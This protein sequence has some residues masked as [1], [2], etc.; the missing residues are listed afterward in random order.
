[1]DYV[2]LGQNIKRFRKIAGLT[3]AKLAE[4]AG[5]CVSFIGQLE[6]ADTKPSL[7]TLVNIAQA[8]SVTVDQLLIAETN[9]PERIYLKEIAERLESY[10]VPHRILLCEMIKSFLDTF[11]QMDQSK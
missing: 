6:T 8:L 5:Y 3:Q 2:A 11:E 9:Y 10:S 4:N 1:M 7:E